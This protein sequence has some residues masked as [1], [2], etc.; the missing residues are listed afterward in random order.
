MKRIELLD[1]VHKILV[2]A[3][4]YVSE[5]CSIRPA[6]FDLVARR[7]NSLLIIKVLTNID[8]ITEDV[9]KEL[10]TLSILLKGCPLIIGEKSGSGKLIDDVIY[11]RFGIQAITPETLKT[12]LLEGLPLEVYAATG[13]LYIN[14]DKDKLKKLRMQQNISLG[15]FARSLRVSRR[16]IQMYEEGMSTSVEIALRIEEILGENI[17]IPIDILNKSSDAG[18]IKPLSLDTDGFREFQREIFSILEQVGYKVIPLERCPFEAVSEDKK[19]ILL[20][21]VDEYNKKLLRKAHVVNSI[22]KITEKHA[23][24]I[25]DKDVNKP[26]IEGTPVIVKKELK[27]IRDPEEILELVLERL[28]KK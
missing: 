23:V 22:S 13:G 8:A 25:T 11:D 6:S 18:E 17:T 20:T 19:K 24:L 10:R 9:S 16:T 15:S 5:L 1:E 3:G 28:Y 12:H 7:D 21:C 14:L 4:F 26:N 27:K 2:K